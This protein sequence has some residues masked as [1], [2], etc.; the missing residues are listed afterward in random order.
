MVIETDVLI[1][2]GGFAGVGTAQDLA[3]N[4]IKTTLV[5]KKD[6]FEV[7]FANLRNLTDPSKTKN[8]ARKL[9]KDFLKSHFIQTR[10]HSLSDSQAELSNG[11]LIKFKRAIIASGTRYPSLSVAKSNTAFDMKSRNQEF[12]TQHEKLKLAKSVLVIGGGVVGVELSGEIVSAF[13]NKTV[14]LS[15]GSETLLDGFKSKAQVKAKEQLAKQGVLFEFNRR[16]QLTDGQYV[17]QTTGKISDADM[18]FEAIGARPNNDFLKPHLSDVLNIKG[19]VKVDHKFA[20][21]GHKT[22]YALGDIADVGEAKLGYLAKQQGLHLAK[23]ITSDLAGK[24]SKA[25]KPNALM[26]L[27]PTGQNSGVMQLPFA[28]TTLNVLINIKQ[29]DLFINKIYKEFG[30]LPNS[31]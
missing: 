18:V 26:A 24:T 31:Q 2:G 20:V 8:M 21:Q 30:T 4:N 27:I 29:K 6:Y 5:D 10:V 9:Y 16:Y 1:I 7:T 28:V 3:K 19:L 23:I 14:T 12:L 22:L 15:H 25:Y 11:D 17:D 13:P